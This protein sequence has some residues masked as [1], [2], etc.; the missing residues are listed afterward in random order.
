M[1]REYRNSEGLL[2]RDG[3][4]PAQELENG[5]KWWWKNGKVHREGGRHAVENGTYKA[6]LVNGKQHREGGL[7]AV[8]NGNYKQWWV[9]GQRHRE[10]GPAIERAD[11]TTEWYVNGQRHRNGG[12]PAAE[13]TNGDKQW[14][15]NGEQHREGGLPAVEDVNDK[16]GA[17]PYGTKLWYIY[18]RELS[19]EQG[20]AYFTFCKKIQEKK[21][22]RAQKKIYF[23]WIQ[24]C[25]DLEHKSGCGQ[26]MAQRNLE[27]F[28]SMMKT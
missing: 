5:I 8:E 19:E 15:V 12:L 22:I 16:V 4:L 25:Y 18:N 17:S 27:V 7:P 26:R 1:T 10:N 13:Y 24:I 11:G 2:H 20:L 3:D 9:N 14:W 21:R 28:E 6:W 23:W